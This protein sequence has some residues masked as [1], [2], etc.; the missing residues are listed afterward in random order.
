[1]L[2]DIGTIGNMGVS[3]DMYLLWGF[4][5]GVYTYIA[6]MTWKSQDV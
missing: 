2:F 6:N 4:P 1:M 3:V 5:C